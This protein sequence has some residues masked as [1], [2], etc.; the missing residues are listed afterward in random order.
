LIK[1]HLKFKRRIK[2]TEV[3]EGLRRSII[4]LLEEGVSGRGNN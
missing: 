1:R 4:D 3:L 2:D